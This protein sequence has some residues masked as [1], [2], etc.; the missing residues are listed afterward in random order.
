MTTTLFYVWFIPVNP[1][2]VLQKRIK[3]Y[4]TLMLMKFVNRLSMFD[5]MNEK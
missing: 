4:G 2:V 5:E 1:A 3:L